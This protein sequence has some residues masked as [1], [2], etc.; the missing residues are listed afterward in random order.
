MKKEI[1]LLL[2]TYFLQSFSPSEYK[3]MDFVFVMD[4]AV[5]EGRRIDLSLDVTMEN[6]SIITYKRNR[7]SLFNSNIY[8]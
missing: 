7:F 5:L 4:G 3:R 2:L 8:I 6:R 1:L